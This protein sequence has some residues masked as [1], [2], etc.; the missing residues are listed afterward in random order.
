M[1]DN[2]R[3]YTGGKFQP[4]YGRPPA[5]LKVTEYHPPVLNPPPHQLPP[6]LPPQS[7]TR[8]V[9]T[10]PTPPAYAT[11]V[12]HVLLVAG[13]LFLSM[14]VAV[15]LVISVN[16]PKQHRLGQQPRI[17]RSVDSNFTEMEVYWEFLVTSGL[18]VWQEIPA[19]GA[20]P[21]I[22]A[23]KGSVQKF[24]VSCTTVDGITLTKGVGFDA[25]AFDA[26]LRYLPINGDIKLL[27]YANNI[28]LFQAK[29]TLFIKIN[30]QF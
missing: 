18:Q 20:I 28:E 27:F 15:I 6:E 30:P 21:D 4:G 17:T 1:G 29:C 3:P 7:E 26:R 11:K 10:T 5:T 12:R 13:F 8:Y 9:N 22:I 14:F 2:R 23:P 25:L 19:T 16:S 24:E